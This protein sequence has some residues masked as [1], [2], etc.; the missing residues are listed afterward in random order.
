MGHDSTGL[1][2]GMTVDVH[3]NVQLAYDAHCRYSRLIHAFSH[4]QMGAYTWSA[5][6]DDSLQIAPCAGQL[7]TPARVAVPGVFATGFLS[8]AVAAVGVPEHA[9]FGTCVWNMRALLVCGKRWTGA[10]LGAAACS[11]FDPRDFVF[12]LGAINGLFQQHWGKRA[13]HS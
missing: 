5:V 7:R 6:R 1:V 9:H 10:Y 13:Q 3:L 4:V 2:W 8:P 12:F 11:E